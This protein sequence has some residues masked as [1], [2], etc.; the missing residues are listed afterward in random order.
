MTLSRRTSDSI[1]ADTVTS[2]TS[3][4]WAFYVENPWHQ[5]AVSG[6]HEQDDCA[7]KRDVPQW[8]AC[9]EWDDDSSEVT[10]LRVKVS[11]LASTLRGE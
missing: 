9:P 6:S 8:Q 1:R 11:A 2:K 4:Q 3:P 10:G 7:M 5:L